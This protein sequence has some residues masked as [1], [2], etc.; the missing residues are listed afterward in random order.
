MFWGFEEDDN[1]QTYPNGTLSPVYKWNFYPDYLT[2]YARGEFL[3]GTYQA[4]YLFTVK[5]CAEGF[6]EDQEQGPNVTTWKVSSSTDIT[7]EAGKL[8]T[9]TITLGKDAHITLD[10]ANAVSIA[11]WGQGSTINVGK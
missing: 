3:P 5:Y 6:N 10:A 4:G 11:P 7:L 9:F 2:D 1:G 8:Y